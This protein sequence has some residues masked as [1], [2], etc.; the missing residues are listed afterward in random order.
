[1]LVS[2]F[3]TEVNTFWWLQRQTWGTTIKDEARVRQKC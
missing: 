3:A 1:M 2:K